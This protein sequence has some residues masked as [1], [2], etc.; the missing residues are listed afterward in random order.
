MTDEKTPPLVVPDVLGILPLRGSVLFPHAVLPLA[1]GRPSSVRLIEDAMQGSRVIGTVAQRNPADDA[2]SRDGLHP[3]GTVAVIHRVLKQPDGT[4]R[5]VV[6]GLGRFRL[7]ELVQDQPFLRARI[8]ALHDEASGARD[9]E[10]EALE[11]SVTALFQKVVSLSPSLPDE[12]ATI[13]TGAD[14]P[15][16]LADLVASALPTLST[17]LKQELLE[18][19]PVKERLSKLAAALGKEAEVLELGSKIQSEVQSEMS[20]TQREY[21]LRE[22]LKAIQKELGDSDDRTQEI[23]SLRQKIEEAGMPEE[24]RR[25][26][27]RE[28]D[29]LAKMPPA[30]AEY[31][32]ARTYIDWLVAMPWRAETTEEINLARARTILDEDHE[33]LEKIKERILEYLAVKKVKPDGKDPILCFVGPPGVGKT[34]LGRSIARALGRKFHRIS[35]GGM[36]DEAEIRGHRRT[37]IGALPGQIVQGL[38]RAGSKNPVFMLDEVDKLGM[39]FRG[40][41]ASA[42]LEVLDPEQNATFRDHYLDVPF[43]LSR[44]LF[45]TT[46]NVIDTVPPPLRDRME[47]LHLAGYTEEEKVRIAGT[48]LVPKQAHEHGVVAGTDVIF[49]PEAL[50][51]IVRRY[52]REAGVRSLEREIASIFRKIARRYAEGPREV[53]TVTPD[54]VTSSLGAPRFEFEELE[55]RTRVPG[56]AVGLVWT[57]VGGDVLFVEATRMPGS[58][59]LTL[60]GQLGDVMKESAQAALSWVRSHARELGIDPDFWERSDVH[61][62]V[63]A[64]AIPKDGPSAGVTMATA[65]VS[66]LTGRPLHA[67]L[68]MTGEISL[69]GRVLPVGGIKEKV[70][71]A[72]RAGVR[73]LILPRRNE[74]NLVEDVPASV[75]DVMT[76]H[77]VDSIED[78]TRLA[79][80]DVRVTDPVLTGL[81]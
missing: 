54:L 50:R 61:V 62:H 34:S 29:R 10:Q 48:H 75:R 26:A 14:G 72:H 25:E 69:S 22:Q 57:P 4:L 1:A 12:L 8:E 23:E 3:I 2:P 5:V 58:R 6:Q 15:G 42:L 11:R 43:D 73:T 78:V 70:L 74:R 37:Y 24:A 35:L 77:L 41:P 81:Y 21:Y 36:R 64:G 31:T 38:R 28:L 76:V 67:A 18:T 68:A 56:V 16:A 79:L 51:L 39:D 47:I 59:T 27:V 46:A 13:A 17:A 63:P 9:L 53:V 7:A 40:D 19:L 44:V 49:T 80:D 30:A 55:E 45:V 60:T 20:K 65:L 52:T 33:G 66:L 71:A 32:V